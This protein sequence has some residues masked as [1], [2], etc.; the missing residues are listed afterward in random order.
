MT[1]TMTEQFT[2]RERDVVRELARGATLAETAE[3]LG[4]GRRTAR[5]HAD[6]MRRK[7][8][9]ET[10]RRLPEAFMRATGIDVFPRPA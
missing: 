4:I 10:H 3:T 8:G 6:Q 2:P 1:A 9:V 5:H 7:L